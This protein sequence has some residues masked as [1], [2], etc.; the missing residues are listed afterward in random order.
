MQAV[1]LAGGKGTRFGS[2]TKTIPKPMVRIG[3]KPIIWHILKLL[4]NRGISEFIICT[5]YKE[6]IIRKYLSSLKEDWKIKCIYT[7]INTQTAK[8]I[9]LISKHI[10]EDYFLMTYGDGLSNIDIK[11]LISTHKRKKKLA[12]VTAVSP[13]PRFGALKIENNLVKKFNEK[14]KDSK[15]LINGG[16]FVL[17]RKIFD[18]LN[19]NKNVMWEQEPMIKLTKN[20]MLAAY[21]HNGFWYPM[22]TERDQKYLTHLYA[23]NPIWLKKKI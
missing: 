5:G 16:F 8:R 12:T 3:N 13:I 2:V 18:Y 1:I 23:K 11:K 14:P 10:K 6:S 17:E 20:K 4:S 7:G 9:G 22:D 19:L 21:T 15:N